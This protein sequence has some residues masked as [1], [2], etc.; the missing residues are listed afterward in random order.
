MR[1]STSLSQDCSYDAFTRPSHRYTFDAGMIQAEEALQV[2]MGID[3][4][5]DLFL[6]ELKKYRAAGVEKP[7]KIEVLNDH[8]ARVV[9]F[10]WETAS[11]RSDF[12]AKKERLGLDLR[13]LFFARAKR[14]TT[15]SN[16]LRSFRSRT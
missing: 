16:S 5:T 14:R 13:Q 11:R 15:R 4:F 2:G 3:D 6:A 1:A 7:L 12:Y 10:T 8:G 9:A